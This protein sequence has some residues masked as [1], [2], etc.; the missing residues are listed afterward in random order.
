MYSAISNP[1]YLRTHPC[2]P[3]ALQSICVGLAY[4]VPYPS[5]GSCG[6]LYSKNSHGDRPPDVEVLDASRTPHF[7]AKCRS[8]TEPG[9]KSIR[10]VS[11]NTIFPLNAFAA[12]A[13][14]GFRPR[15]AVIYTQSCK[16]SRKKKVE[17]GAFWRATIA[18][19][20]TTAKDNPF[21]TRQPRVLIASFR[22]Y[23]H[24]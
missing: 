5:Q 10:S 12:V 6:D 13:N 19:S 3:L 15:L 14:A 4:V 1:D 17:R 20:I 7:D 18:L 16:L 8:E 21:G 22:S 11:V 2:R 9:Y 23:L 24:C